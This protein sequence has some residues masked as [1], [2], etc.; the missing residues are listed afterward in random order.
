MQVATA[1][2]AVR[3]AANLPETLVPFNQDIYLQSVTPPIMPDLSRLDPKTDLQAVIAIARSPGL[4]IIGMEKFTS[5]DL[6]K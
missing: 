3:T 2:L 6:T 4:Q 5:Q 1:N